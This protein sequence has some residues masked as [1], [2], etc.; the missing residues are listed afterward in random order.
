MTACTAAKSTC[1]HDGR[2]FEELG[3]QHE[4]RNVGQ[5]QGGWQTVRCKLAV[6][7]YS[8]QHLQLHSERQSSGVNEARG[9]ISRTGSG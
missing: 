9:R 7:R 6:K 4:A 8:M 1:N 2:G 3:C 5:K